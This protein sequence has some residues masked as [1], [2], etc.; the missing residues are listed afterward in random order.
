MLALEL[1]GHRPD[2]DVRAALLEGGREPLV[3]VG[4]HGVVG[5]A[6]REVLAPGLRRPGV[7]CGADAE[8]GLAEDADVVVLA[9]Q[10]A[11]DVGRAVDGPVVDQQD[12]ELGVGLREQALHARLEL[13][14]RVVER[15]DHAQAGQ[16][17]SARDAAPC[18]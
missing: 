10:V 8:V 12:L 14:D 2:G 3:A 5:V 4:Q 16:V 13:S 1:E 15:H 17:R 9:G 7:A 11:R 6:E 18:A